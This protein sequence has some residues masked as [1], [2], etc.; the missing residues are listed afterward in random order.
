MDAKPHSPAAEAEATPMMAQYL[1]IKRH[2][3]DAL[4]LY[5][6][7]D[8]YELFFADAEKASA[9]LG[10]ALTKRG[11]HKGSD[12]PMCGV[13]VHALDQYL[14]KLIR[15]GHRVAIAEQ[16]ED[17]AEAKK[18]GSKSVVARDV[19]RLITPGT[20]TE[21][22]LL[23]SSASNYLACL[24]SLRATGEMALAF[25]EISTGEF[26]VMATDYGRLAA[27]LAR[28]S[29]SEIL[30]N[31]SLFE[32]SYTAAVING[33]G[34]AITPLSS[35]RFDSA[36]ATHA[37]KAH[38]QVEALEVFGN[39]RRLDLAALG[40]LLDYIKITQVGH[41]PHLRVPRLE[42][43]EAG[44]LIDAA[45]RANLELSRT[46]SGQRKGSLLDCL[47]ATV[48]A[49]GARL[50]AD[51]VARPLAVPEAINA[52][53][54]A[55]AHFHSDEALNEQVRK[56]LRALPDLERALGRIT[57]SRGGPRDLAAI[58]AAVL[59]TE[60]LQLALR[61]SGQLSPVPLPIA[62]IMDQLHAAP[63][64]H[65]FE[66]ARALAPELPLF[67]RDGGF[68]A[69][70]Y[71]P[72]LDENRKLR[73][74]TR[75]VIAKL[76][77]DYAEI[78]GVKALKIKH[79]NILGYFI[80]VTA[81]QAEVLKASALAQS[82]IHRQSIASAVRFTTV[83]LGELEQKIA[84]AG[85]RVLALE[86]EIFRRLAEAVVGHRQALSNAAQGL[87]A[88]DVYSSLAQVA[89]QRRYVRPMVDD[90]LAFEITAGRHPVVEE[91]LRRQGERGF[92]ANDSD[93]SEGHKSLW[94]LTGP[95]MAGKSTYLRQNALIA[96]M[97]Q[98][99]SFVPAAR[100]HIGVLDRLYSR[101][102]AADD[103]ARGR[104]T[105]MVE[106]IETAAILNQATA[107]SL[108]I[109]DEIG[110]G[111]AT[112]DG[113]SIAWATLEHLHDVNQSRALFATHYHELTSLAAT[114]KNL[115]CATMKVKEWNGDIVFLHEVV[116]G[117]AERSYGIQAAKLAG[118]PSSVIQRATE[119]LKRLE[120]GKGHN[121][122]QD[123][124]AELP[125][126]AATAQIKAEAKP[127]LLRANLAKIS[128]DELSPREALSLLYELK[129]MA[130]DK[131]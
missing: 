64:E 89:R 56:L 60:D 27:D 115:H 87:A 104:S 70:G 48:T 20:L 129:Q 52:R 96:I 53:L 80:E 77:A 24:T 130:K 31:E 63:H 35:S 74:D 98:M 62:E 69:E 58:S 97:A 120:A 54:D 124:A 109:L 108:V 105:F 18:R 22:T 86:L 90:S 75:Q 46:L 95:N 100:A 125:L 128:P 7:G 57:S 28:L 13:P 65:A 33:S 41:M 127:D 68:V 112:Y 11:K 32:E 122:A 78:S 55:I 12:I 19:I 40:A 111:T 103:L 17:P 126:F 25:A 37:L 61:G 94:L 92:A 116:S 110:R 34:A 114:L 8:F 117:T 5:R 131:T 2:H 91:A 26:V 76:Q 42:A 119:V 107:R 84:L 36:S 30:V 83:E 113:L 102:G 81:Q 73:D 71:A 23:E 67:A 39:F 82:L 9:T 15:H 21:E 49:A 29:P 47:D 99:G 93:L 118:L 51:F 121:K 50:L 88:L 79:N 101:V 72:E 44:L 45:T 3:P 6:M 85:S 66:V 38:Y 14:Q 106:M 43:P 10:I 123:L 1:E 4:L 16:I 59:A